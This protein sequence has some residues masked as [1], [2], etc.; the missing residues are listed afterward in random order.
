[1][2][3]HGNHSLSPDKERLSN[4]R[5]DADEL[6]DATQQRDSGAAKVNGHPPT[7]PL[8]L[9][10]KYDGIAHHQ[11]YRHN[12]G[13]QRNRGY[14]YRYHDSSPTTTKGRLVLVPVPLEYRY[15]RVPGF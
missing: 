13:N 5:V 2:E 11:K 10:R 6:D 7:P 8:P 14:E 4:D 1:M 15:C 3:G 9:P 12:D